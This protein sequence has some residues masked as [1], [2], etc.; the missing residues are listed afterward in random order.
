[1]SLL[2]TSSKYEKE[3]ESSAKTTLSLTYNVVR[4]F[5]LIHL[6][7]IGRDRMIYA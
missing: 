6:S 3:L 5:K 4:L 2:D 7:A 1:M